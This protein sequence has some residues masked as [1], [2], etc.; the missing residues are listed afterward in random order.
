VPFSTVDPLWRGADHRTRTTVEDEMASLTAV[1]ARMDLNL[2]SVFS[3]AKSMRLIF[4]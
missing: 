4:S 3:L 1:G 2:K